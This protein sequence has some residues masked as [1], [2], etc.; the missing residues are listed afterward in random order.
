MPGHAPFD[1]WK[2]PIFDPDLEEGWNWRR[3]GK[4]R[5]GRLLDG[6]EWNEIPAPP[7]VPEIS[8]GG[9]PASSARGQA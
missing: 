3:L 1:S 5:A 4:K 2:A 9:A 7:P 6:R 8:A